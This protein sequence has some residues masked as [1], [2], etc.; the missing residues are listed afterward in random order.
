MVAP[1]QLSLRSDVVP[2]DPAVVDH[3]RDHPDPVPRGGVE[4]ELGGPGLER[5]ED[6]HRPVD[7]LAEALEAADEVEGEAVG[8]SRGDADRAGK[9]SVTERRHAVPH[10]LALIPGA[11]RVVEQK[12]VEARLPEAL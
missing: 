5:V 8:G 4:A 12:Q 9:S 7:R 3:A 6:D 1:R 11:V 10:L 2:E